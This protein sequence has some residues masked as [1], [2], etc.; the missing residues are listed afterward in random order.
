MLYFVKSYE[1]IN[2]LQ[3]I[4]TQLTYLFVNTCDIMCIIYTDTYKV[5]TNQYFSDGLSNIC[6]SFRWAETYSFM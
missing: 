4:I 5:H 6:M 1:V 2:R 3:Y